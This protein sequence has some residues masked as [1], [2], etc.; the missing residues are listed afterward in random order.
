MRYLIEVN[1]VAVSDA[2]DIV[3]R[4]LVRVSW[5]SKPC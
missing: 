1:Q 4:R 3:L 5:E 2:V